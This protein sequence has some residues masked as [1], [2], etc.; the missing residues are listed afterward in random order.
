VEAKAMTVLLG[1]EA[2]CKDLGEVLRRDSLTVV[3]DLDDELIW[4]YR[5]R[6]NGNLSPHA[7]G[8]H[9]WLEASP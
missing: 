7:A 6:A 3:G 5:A 8:G 9:G 4:V 1:R 2:M